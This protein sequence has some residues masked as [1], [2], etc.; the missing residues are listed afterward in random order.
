MLLDTRSRTRIPTR[1]PIDGALSKE[2]VRILTILAFASLQCA[3]RTQAS[4]TKGDAGV[5]L[6]R[7]SAADTSVVATSNKSYR[8]Q[9]I[10]QME[11][12]LTQI[13]D[14]HPLACDAFEPLGPR[15]VRSARSK[16]YNCGGAE[17]VRT[18][19]AP[20]GCYVPVADASCDWFLW[21]VPKTRDTPPVPSQAFAESDP[22]TSRMFLEDLTMD[23]I[24]EAIVLTRRQ[25]PRDDV[26]IVQSVD[27]FG[28]SR[29]VPISDLKDVDSDGRLDGVL[30]LLTFPDD[31]SKR[32]GPLLLAHRR[33][34]G[35][36][37]LKDAAA[38]SYRSRVCHAPLLPVI[39]KKAGQLQ[40]HETARRIV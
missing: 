25:P 17:N 18:L 7:A 11:R 5:P 1:N 9:L 33:A 29:T 19:D 21:Y 30:D 15:A 27:A 36:F 12:S 2:G 24:P 13:R 6:P 38:R 23:G 34:D 3:C 20:L 22:F 39:H 37:S 16:E 10:Q 35:R 26:V 32:R 40:K 31:D 8:V 14:K 4:T 28:T